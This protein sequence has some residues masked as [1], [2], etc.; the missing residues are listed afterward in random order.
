MQGQHH[1]LILFHPSTVAYPLPATWLSDKFLEWIHWLSTL[2]ILNKMGFHRTLPQSMV[3]APCSMGGVR[4]C[5]L[6]Y[7]QQAQQIIILIQHLHASS[8]LGHTLEI[9]IR[10]YQLWAGI[11]K[12][13]LSNMQPCPWIPNHW[14]SFVC[15][16]MQDNN[17]TIR[18][19]SWTILPLHTND[20]FLMEDIRD[21][22][23]PPNQLEKLNACWMYLQVMTLAKIT[24]QAGTL[25]AAPPGTS[26]PKAPNT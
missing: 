26:M 23:I 10:K 5:N 7:K 24:N 14:L 17:M 4:L 2:M 1:L 15:K 20:H 16:A 6:S 25:L 9:I 21:Y 19:D 18:Y 13:V 22:R 12:H 8:P 3:F 11:H